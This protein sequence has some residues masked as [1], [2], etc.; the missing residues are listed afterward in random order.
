[1]GAS[2]SSSSN[3]S[4]IVKYDKDG[5]ELWR[6]TYSEPGNT[7][8]SPIAFEFDNKGNINVL[9]LAF[10]SSEAVTYSLTPD[11]VLRWGYAYSNADLPIINPR[12]LATDTKGNSYVTGT[13]SNSGTSNS[14]DIF[15]IKVNKNGVFQWAQQYDGPTNEGDFSERVRTGKK[16]SVFVGGFTVSGSFNRNMLVLKY[17]ADGTFLW[18]RT[19]DGPDGLSDQVSDMEVDSKGAVIIVGHS[20]SGRAILKYDKDGNLNYEK[21]VAGPYNSNHSLAFDAKKAAIITSTLSTSDG[22]EIVKYD[23][24]GNSEWGPIRIPLKMP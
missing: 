21:N 1:M 11:G 22:I 3:G 5:V 18:E 23:K 10:S 4:I 17:A 8:T 20:F 19:Y 7:Q 6:H 14:K 13:I 15:L 12:D 24:N 2:H 16:G 9:A